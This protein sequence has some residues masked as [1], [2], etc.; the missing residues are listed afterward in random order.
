M[1]AHHPYLVVSVCGSH[2]VHDI[3]CVRKFY[4]FYNIEIQLSSIAQSTGQYYPIK[5][6]LYWE[7]TGKYSP[8]WQSNTD[9]QLF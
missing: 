7:S 5:V 6:Q 2:Q 4:T 9:N 3:A 1:F 8:S